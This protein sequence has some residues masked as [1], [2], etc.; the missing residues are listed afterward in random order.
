MKQSF[1]L[2]IALLSNAFAGWRVHY[3][4]EHKEG[5]YFRPESVSMSYS[6]DNSDYQ[7]FPEAL[8]A[9]KSQGRINQLS[10]I[11]PWPLTESDIFQSELIAAFKKLAPQEWAEAEKSAGNMHNPKMRSLRKHLSK[12]FMHT[13]LSKELARDLKPFDLVITG[14]GQEKLRYQKKGKKRIIQGIFHIGIAPQK[15]EQV[16][17]PNPLPAE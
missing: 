6:Q 5:D 17:A 4:P 2:F 10:F 13:S 7:T 14:F 8:A 3:I 12:A 11:R 15:A 1:I 9:V 16:G